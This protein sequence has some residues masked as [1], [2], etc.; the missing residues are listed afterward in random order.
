MV[1]DY[2][3]AKIYKLI[4]NDG[5]YYY[6]STCETLEERFQ[7]HKYKAVKYPNR[8]VYKR[9]FEVGWNNVQPILVTD[10]CHVENDDQLREFEDTFIEPV[11][12]DLKCLNEFRAFLCLG[13]NNFENQ[14]D[15]RKESKK[16]YYESHKEIINAHAKQYREQNQEK[17]SE[18]RKPYLDSH[19]KEKSDYDKIY[20]E[21]NKEKIKQ[22]DSQPYECEICNLTMRYQ[23]K[24]RHSRTKT[25]LANM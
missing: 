24:Y 2:S 21:K 9:F 8:K 20:R 3:Q 12:N 23:E 1:K 7:N 17:I 14:H 15:W 6:G 4:D 16:K 18:Q 10:D 11:L 19:K 22:R 5:Y 13:V 25:H